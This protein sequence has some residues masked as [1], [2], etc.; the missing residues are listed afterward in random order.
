MGRFTLA[1]L[2]KT[3][4]AA[5]RFTDLSF[6]L[7]LGFLSVTQKATVRVDI[8]CGANTVYV[9]I[10][11]LIDSELERVG[12]VVSVPPANQQPN[13]PEDQDHNPNSHQNR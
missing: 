1:A 11:R 13:R 8:S 6:N 7:I 9:D 5:S 12:V 10:D 4:S 3:V 2:A